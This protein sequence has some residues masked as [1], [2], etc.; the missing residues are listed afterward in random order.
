MIRQPIYAHDFAS[1]PSDFADL[2]VGTDWASDRVYVRKQYTLYDVSRE[3]LADAG[4]FDFEALLRPTP[5]STQL[6]WAI[7]DRMPWNVV[8][9]NWR[10]FRLR[11][12]RRIGG[13]IAGESLRDDD[14]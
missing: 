1:V 9:R 5:W 10:S 8:R 14:E 12:G 13:W 4:G 2:I 11:T 3:L 6:Y 7:E